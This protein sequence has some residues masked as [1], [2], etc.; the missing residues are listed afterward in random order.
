MSANKTSNKAE[1]MLGYICYTLRA[2][3]LILG[4]SAYLRKAI[5]GFLDDWG[6]PNRTKKKPHPYRDEA[7][8]KGSNNNPTSNAHKRYVSTAMELWESRS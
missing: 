3:S 5:L 8:L 6:P 1:V 4:R 2:L 7:F